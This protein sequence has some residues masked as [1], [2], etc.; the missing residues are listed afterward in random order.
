MVNQWKVEYTWDQGGVFTAIQKKDECYIKMI[1][2]YLRANPESKAWYL[3]LLTNLG[4]ILQ[5]TIKDATE[6]S[7]GNNKESSES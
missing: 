1:G 2:P 5:I 7:S 4:A 6:E 3:I